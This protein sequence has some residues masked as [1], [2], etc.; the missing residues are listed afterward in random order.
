MTPLLA[1]LLAAAPPAP[2][3]DW[4]PLAVPAQSGASFYDSGSVE[5]S[6][7]LVRVRVRWHPEDAAA[8]F[9][10]ARVLS[11]IDCRQRTGQIMSMTVYDRA[12]E[13]IGSDETPQTVDPVREG[14]AA[15]SLAQA[16][17]PRP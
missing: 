10:E 9:H 13:V 7:D 15:H 1:L 11:Q 8:P 5:R 17:C 14:Y 3:G 2:A 6:G 4:V 16:L 12:G